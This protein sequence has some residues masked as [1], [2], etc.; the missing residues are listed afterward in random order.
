M[1]KNSLV[2]GGWGAGGRGQGGSGSMPP[3]KKVNSQIWASETCMHAC[4]LISYEPLVVSVSVL[5][6]VKNGIIFKET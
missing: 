2:S 3:R 4:M 6:H 1:E 5:N